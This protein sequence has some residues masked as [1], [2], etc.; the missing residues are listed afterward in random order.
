M[1]DLVALFGSKFGLTPAPGLCLCSIL[2]IVKVYFSSQQSC[3]STGWAGLGKLNPDHK[4]PPR[5]MQ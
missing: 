3:R 4:A 1:Y 2:F 5:V